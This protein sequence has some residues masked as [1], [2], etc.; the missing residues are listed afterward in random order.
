MFRLTFELSL[1]TW[2]CN[3]KK[4]F[5]KLTHFSELSPPINLKLGIVWLKSESKHINGLIIIKVILLTVLVCTR[6]TVFDSYC[7]V[8]SNHCNNLPIDV[9]IFFFITS[10]NLGK[11]D[12]T[13]LVSLNFMSLLRIVI[14]CRKSFIY[15]SIAYHIG[16]ISRFNAV[17]HLVR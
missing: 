14:I 1:E 3:Y 16:F 4:S 2:C 11:R 13:I 8:I 15:L 7:P 10:I 12:P 6:I 17:S 5:H 9:D